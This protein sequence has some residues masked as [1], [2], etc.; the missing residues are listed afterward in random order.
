MIK[1]KKI[2]YIVAGFSSP[3]NKL[4]EKSFSL[5]IEEENESKQNKFSSFFSNIF[6]PDT[7]EKKLLNQSKQKLCAF[8]NIEELVRFIK[9]T[10]SSSA[11]SF[12]YYLKETYDVFIDSL[13]S[14]KT[15]YFVVL[16]TFPQ[17][18]FSLSGKIAQ[19]LQEKLPISILSRLYWIKSFPTHASYILP[20]KQMIK[21]LMKEKN[22]KEEETIFLFSASNPS[23]FEQEIDQLFFLECSFSSKEILKGFPYILGNLGYQSG[24]Y[25]KNT[26]YTPSV[27]MLIEQIEQWG[28]KRKNIVFIPLN[29]IIDDYQSIYEIE[30]NFIPSLKKKNFEVCLCPSLWANKWWANSFCN[31]LEENTFVT[32]NML[33]PPSGIR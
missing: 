9:K 18:S 16:P 10:C 28:E 27:S 19:F 20:I 23:Y 24:Y 29:L 15:D 4:E 26:S 3:R 6:S 2:S 31:I 17:F 11:F 30:N 25:K 12:H 14:C 1:T 21:K 8:E 5:A 13:T 7:K 32:N 22:Y 33:L